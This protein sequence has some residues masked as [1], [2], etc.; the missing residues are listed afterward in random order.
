M[1]VV[2]QHSSQGRGVYYLRFK[3]NGKSSSIKLGRTS[4]ISLDDARKKVTDYR[5][6]IAQGIDPREAI[7]AKNSVPLFSDFFTNTYLPHAKLHKRSWKCDE[8]L[9]RLQLKRAFGH[10]KLNQIT[11]MQVQSLHSELRESGLAASTSDHYAQLTRHILNMA[12]DF[13]LIDKNP[14]SGIKLFREDNQVTVSLSED[15]LGHL[16][17]VLKTHPNRNACNVVLFLLNTGLRISSA[18]LAKWEHIDISQK[19]MLLPSSI[20]KNKRVSSIPLSS[21]ALEILDGL[22]TKGKHEYL[23]VNP[24]TN[25]RLTTISKGWRSIRAEAGLPQLKLHGCRHLFAGLVI[26]SGVS[27]FVLSKLL[28]HANVLTTSRY[29]YL[30]K[31]TLLDA[32]NT[33]SHSIDKAL[34]AIS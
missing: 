8:S 24:N 26:N 29:S 5:S 16:V 33:A 17:G 25:K 15:E 4:D 34:K 1:Y 9:Y 6:Q 20:S 28:T 32:A 10:L 18:L 23:F 11:R 12:Q 13:D 19:T 30:D 31:S 3:L 21:G 22:P 27:I 7:K 2:A 14:V